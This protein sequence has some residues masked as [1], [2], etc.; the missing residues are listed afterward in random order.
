MQQ[1]RAIPN[2]VRPAG[3]LVFVDDFLETTNLPSSIFEPNPSYLPKSLEAL[4]YISLE[5]CAKSRLWLRTELRVNDR[6]YLFSSNIHFI[7]NC[8]EL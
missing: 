6:A 2:R 3:C 5:Q 1:A 4:Y 8:D 7:K